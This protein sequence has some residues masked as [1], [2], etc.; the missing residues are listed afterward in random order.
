MKPRWSRTLRKSDLYLAAML[1]PLVRPGSSR[2]QSGP[3]EDLIP[4]L[5]KDEVRG[6]WLAPLARRDIRAATVEIFGTALGQLLDPVLEEMVGPFHRLLLDGD[7]LLGLEL[8]DEL[9]H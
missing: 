9:L 8:V 2:G 6:V 1:R 4:S 7:A 5:S 3:H